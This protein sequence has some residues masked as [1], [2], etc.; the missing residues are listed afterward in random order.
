MSLFPVGP[1]TFQLDRFYKLFLNFAASARSVFL[2]YT[3]YIRIVCFGLATDQ[4]DKQDIL[5]FLY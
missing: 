5:F 3:L 4:L 1:C 2:R